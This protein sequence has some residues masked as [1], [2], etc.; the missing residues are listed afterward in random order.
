MSCVGLGRDFQFLEGWV[1][2][3]VAKVL[4]FEK[5]MLMHLKYG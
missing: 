1:G 3:T 5:I 2:S 4:K